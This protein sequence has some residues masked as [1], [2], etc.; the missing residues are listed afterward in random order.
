MYRPFH[1]GPKAHGFRP[2][3]EMAARLEE[4]TE[5]GAVSAVRRDIRAAILQLLAEQPMHGFQIISELG[6]R[7][8]GDWNPRPGVVYPTLQLL[9]DEGL[10]DS[11]QA[12]G[13][14]VYHLTEDGR[15]A[16]AGFA[17]QSASWEDAASASDLMG[18]R[19]AAAMLAQVV[20]QVGATG[21][22]A[23]RAAAHEVLVAARK[24]LHT[25]LAQD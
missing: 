9:A 10:V 15:A 5:S 18:Y 6:E 2:L 20:V 13:K 3:S 25:I 19:Q 22:E 1:S 7:S 4:F 21:S 23:Q 8:G 17:G 24:Q 12:N 11:E 16:V 14:K